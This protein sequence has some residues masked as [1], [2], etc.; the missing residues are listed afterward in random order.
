MCKQHEQGLSAQDLFQKHANSM[1]QTMTGMGN[2]FKDNCLELLALDSRN[3]ATESVVETV[4][5][6]KSIGETQYQNYVNVVIK[7]RTVSIHKPIKKN[8]LPLLK[9]QS[10]KPATKS[11]QKIAILRRDCN[12]FSHLFIVSK[13]QD[14]NLDDF[15]SH[16]NHP[17]LP[18]IS[19]HGKPRFPNRKAELLSCLVDHLWKLL[20]H[21]M[22][23]YL[24]ALLLSTVFLL[25]SAHLRNMPMKCSCHGLVNN[26][27]SVTGSTLF[28]ISMYLAV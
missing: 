26:S 6:I 27:V 4:R 8:S 9:R 12:L 21:S 25:R 10:S 2:P 23:K 18:S 11:V 28:G 1:Y 24:M 13:F 16:E 7:T 14:G 5:N 19:E 3:C 22:L 15:F 20:S 17:W